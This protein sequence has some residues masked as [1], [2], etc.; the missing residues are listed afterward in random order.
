MRKKRYVGALSA[1]NGY[2]MM[3]TLRRADQVL[4]VAGL[5]IPASRKPDD[6]EVKLAEQLVEAISADFE[7]QTWHDEY[8]ERVLKLIEAKARGAKIA[9]KP[10]KPVAAKGG[11]AEQLQRSL[12]MA[13]EKKVA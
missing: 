1:S 9:V 8:R 2:L 11:L 10:V 12:S 13:K 5:D 3:L 6:K 4:A 7:P